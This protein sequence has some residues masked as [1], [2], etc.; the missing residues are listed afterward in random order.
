MLTPRLEQLDNTI[1]VGGTRNISNHPS[2]T[3]GRPQSSQPLT[4]NKSEETF[5]NTQLPDLSQPDAELPI[6]IV[7]AIPSSLLK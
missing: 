3:P 5:L 7:R 6:Q 1:H 2:L 4:F